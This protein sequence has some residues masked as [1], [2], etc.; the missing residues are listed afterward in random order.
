MPFVVMTELDVKP[1]HFAA[2]RAAMQGVAVA[3]RD[4]SACD[5]YGLHAAVDGAPRLITYQ[6]WRDRAAYDGFHAAAETR[7]A[8]DA[9]REW[10]AGAVRVTELVDVL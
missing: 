3:A 8:L 10:L 5:M 2:A 7:L 9:M 4:A 6:R 1:E